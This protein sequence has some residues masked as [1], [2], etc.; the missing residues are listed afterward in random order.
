MSGR[1]IGSVLTG[2]NTYEDEKELKT[3]QNEVNEG[4]ENVYLFSI[5]FLF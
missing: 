2:Q 3:I 5:H 4:T 1:S